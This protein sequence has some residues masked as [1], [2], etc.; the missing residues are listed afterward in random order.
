MIQGEAIAVIR[1]NDTSPIESKNTRLISSAVCSGASFASGHA[2]SDTIE[3][4]GGVKKRTVTWMMDGSKTIRFEPIQESEEI[5]F[6]EFHNRFNSIE[7]CQ[8]NPNH[9]ISYMRSNFE[10]HSHMVDK[11]KTM[12]PMLKIRNGSRIAI[13][14]SGTDEASKAEREKILSNL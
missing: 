2:Y 3:D 11:I 1:D 6:M 8:K 14:P 5:S 12:R 4:V 7:W 13:V 9:P 10:Q